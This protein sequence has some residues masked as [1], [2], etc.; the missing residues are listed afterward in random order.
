MDKTLIIV[1]D[2]FTERVLEYS[3][4]TLFDY[5]FLDEVTFY[6]YVSNGLGTIDETQTTLTD[7]TGGFYRVTPDD[8][9]YSFER[10]LEERLIYRLGYADF[11]AIGL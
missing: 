8:F 4:V 1:L 2:E 9:E 10:D 11:G 3:N 5:G 7:P 6:D